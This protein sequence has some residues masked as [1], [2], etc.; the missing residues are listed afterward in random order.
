MIKNI[1]VM[2]TCLGSLVFM[3]AC[4]RTEY[5]CSSPEVL[6]RLKETEGRDAYGVT[7]ETVA[8]VISGMK[9]HRIE[10]LSK[11]SAGYKCRAVFDYPS[12]KLPEGMS[13]DNTGV[14]NAYSD[15]LRY[16]VRVTDD[17]GELVVQFVKK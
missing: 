15:V 8:S 9:I 16:T 17:G 13:N 11:D 3:S 2:S 6:Q 7:A 1:V 14:A 12:Y 10:T 4:G 5:N